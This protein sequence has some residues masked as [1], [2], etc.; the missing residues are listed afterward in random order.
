MSK[1]RVSVTVDPDVAEYLDRDAINTS[2]LVNRLLKD[3]MDGTNETTVRMLE[4]RREQLQSECDELAARLDQKQN[5]L[6]RVEARI[7]ELE[8]EREDRIAEARELIPPKARSVGNPAVETWA[9][10]LDMGEEELIGRLNEG[11]S[12]E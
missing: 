11:E 5:D 7:D 4:L 12:D 10:K 8:D 1:E 3:E 2:G 6:Q 9:N